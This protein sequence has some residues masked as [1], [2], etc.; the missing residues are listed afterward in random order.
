MKFYSQFLSKF[1]NE[2]EVPSSSSA[3]HFEF[4][5]NTKTMLGLK[6]AFLSI[7]KLITLLMQIHVPMRIILTLGMTSDHKTQLVQLIKCLYP[8]IQCPFVQ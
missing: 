8:Y 4:N 6:L 7:F 1:L 5:A 2:L 3:I